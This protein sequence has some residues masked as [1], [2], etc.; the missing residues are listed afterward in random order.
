MATI[1]QKRAAKIL[2]DFIGRGENKPA[3]EI[4]CEAG[5]SKSTS[6]TPGLV[7]KSK[8]WNELVEE[9]L[10]DTFL[11]TKHEQLLDAKIKKRRIVKGELVDETEE[12]DRDAIELTSLLRTA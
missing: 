10:P 12:E 3:G 5:Y 2:S 1:K 11:A 9:F 7:T 4:L 6:E 8:T